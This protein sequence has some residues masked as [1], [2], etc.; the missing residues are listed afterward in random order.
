MPASC[1]WFD[2][3]AVEPSDTDAEIDMP[4]DG[5]L[6]S[7]TDPDLPL[8]GDIP[9]EPDTD[10]DANDADIADIEEDVAPESVF[11]PL[12]L[13]PGGDFI[14][15]ALVPARSDTLYALAAYQR[16]F[17]SSD[18]ASTW[19]ECTGS[20]PDVYT[21]APTA[22]PPGDI[23]IGGEYGV[24]VSHDGCAS[25]VG[26][27]LALETYALHILADGDVL[28]GTEQGL[29]RFDGSSWSTLISTLEGYYV[30]SLSGSA[31]GDVVFAGAYGNGMARSSDGGS[32]WESCNSGLASLDVHHVAVAQ[33][34]PWRVY[35]YTE[36]GLERS[37]DGGD[38]W[39]R[40]R[41]DGGWALAAD[42]FDADF[43]VFYQWNHLLE[44]WD[45]GD[46]FGWRDRRSDN[47]SLASI[48]D[49]L[50]DAS[51]EG[52]LYA[53]TGRGVFRLDDMSTWNWTERDAGLSAWSIWDVAAAPVTGTLYLATPTGVLRSTNDG[54]SWS[55][56]ITGFPTGLYSASS[57]TVSVSTDE[58]DPDILAAGGQFV[59]L[60]TDG[61][62]TF[63]LVF[64]PDEEDYWWVETV[65]VSGSRLYAGTPT[66]FHYSPD[67][68]SSWFPHLVGGEE[69]EVYDILLYEDDPPLVVVATDTG[70]FSTQDNGDSFEAFSDGLSSQEVYALARLPGGRLFAGTPDGVFSASAPGERWERRSPEACW[71]DDVMV[72]DSSIFAACD[73]GVFWSGDEGLTWNEIPDLAGKWPICMCVDGGGNLLVGTWGFGLHA[74]PLP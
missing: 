59:M 2:S 73:E 24:L 5:V 50:F 29:R 38:T 10:A 13:P 17:R 60:S 27:G 56:E 6:D 41:D 70:I 53:A 47:M 36:A 67:S 16:I 33:G 7:E 1:S 31:D 45:G 52:L 55:I 39:S 46:T 42:P 28:A 63:D 8:D 15:L 22:D 30:M 65:E 62:S 40:I 57:Y 4:D 12:G 58:A 49:L 61:G 19:T 51:T 26:T 43:V 18:G 3:H 37:N 64:D 34:D 68:G 48:E 14:T 66:R 21:V 32:S 11:S 23:F 25:W 35:T 71:A 54:A 72:H 69:R 74:A 9:Q 44:S 20:E